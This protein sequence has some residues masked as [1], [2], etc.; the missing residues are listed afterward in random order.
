MIAIVLL[1]L[2]PLSA[3][4]NQANTG[5]SP[6]TPIV[7]AGLG[8]GTVALDGP[9]RFHLGDNPAWAT[10][11]FDDSAW[12]QLSA[13]LPWGAQGHAGSTGFAWYRS[14]ISLASASDTPL[15]FSLL[16]SKVGD[17][18][19]VYWNGKLVGGSGKLQPFPVWYFPQPAQV[20]DLGPAKSGELAVRVWKAPLLSDD[21]GQRGGFESAPIIGSPQAISTAKA[22]L[23]YQWLSSRQ[24]LFGE[25]LIY[26]IVA[27]L[28]FLLW[29]RNSS[30]WLL[31]WMTGFTVVPPLN[32]LLL[33]TH[34]AWPYA[35]S[36][37]VDQPLTTVRDISLWFLLLWLLGLHQNR[38]IARLTRILAMIGF[39]NAILDGVLVA[40]YAR[41]QFTRLSQVADAASTAVYM[42]LET[43]PLVLV[44]YAFFARKRADREKLDTGH[45][46]VASLAFFTE[47]IVVVRSGAKQGRQFTNWSLASNIDSPLFS[48]GGSA[49]SAHTFATALLLVAII[50][51]VYKSIRAD[52]RR[53]DMLEREKM[54]LTRAR[55]QM[56]YHAEHDDLTGLW[57][58]RIIVE[59]LRSEVERMRRDRTPLSVILVD[60]DHFKRVNDLF[61][62]FSGDLV[63]Q[64]VG[65][66]FTHSVRTYDW[67]GR[68]GGE[69]FLL[70]L[71]GSNIENA[72]LRAEEL[73][74]AVQAAQIVDGETTIQVTA[75]FGVAS[76]FPNH[77][78]AEAVIQTVDGALYQAKNRGRNCVVAAKSGIALI[79]K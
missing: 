15:Q 73:R 5:T 69:E 6:A 13:D 11:G 39:V 48:L 7:I 45:W 72:L 14:N 74:Q 23:D 19:E 37:A 10:P 3:S 46:L 34:I 21:S 43:F 79:Q 58:H 50:Y 24:F 30:R 32:L 42:L 17:A 35:F 22:A 31:F 25:N 77:Y 8:K 64:K 70:I 41:P 12:E 2:A 40:I 1:G 63:L 20:I 27:L 75:S 61:G 28:S 71:P 51:A 29:C 56:R 47:V 33:N 67:I 68:Y 66:I 44:G 16:L 52:Q 18:Y 78:E 59:R 60:I 49:I 76:E 9:W 54:E 38:S 53:Q 65:E 57:N 62:H 36:I 4:A 26:A 55:D